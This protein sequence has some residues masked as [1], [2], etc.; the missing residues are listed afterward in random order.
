[1]IEKGKRYVNARS[2]GTFMLTE[3]WDD[4]GDA[5]TTLERML[6]A[7]TG[8]SSFPH[9]HL[10]FTQT[11]TGLQGEGHVMVD[12]EERPLNP[13]DKVV[14]EPGTH[15]R[16]P[17]NEGP[18]E[19]I[20][21]GEFDPV[22][23]FIKAYGEAYVNRAVAGE[24]NDQDEFSILQIFVLTQATDGQSFGAGPPV[25]IQRALSPLL[26]PIGRLRGYRAS[27]D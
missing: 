18:G 21:R 22:P 15:H 9:L 2:G 10:D 24:L 12:G 6:P 23:E 7:N 20:V 3:H 11:W 4:T 25:A 26:G 13:G 16:D 5:H 19:L 17:W 1:V 14:I 8:K 27:Y